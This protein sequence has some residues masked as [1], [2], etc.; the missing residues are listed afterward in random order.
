MAVT[1][2]IILLVCVYGIICSIASAEETPKVKSSSVS[3]EYNVTCSPKWMIVTVSVNSTSAQ[4]Y[5]ERL[6][7]YPDCQAELL[8][9]LHVFRLPLD[10][11]YSC[12][13]TRMLNKITGVRIYYHRVIV[14]EPQEEL[15]MI[16]VT[17]SIPPT[18][19]TSDPEVVHRTRRNTLP[20]NFVEPDYVNITDYIVASAPVPYLN[21]AVRQHGKIMD[22]TL[23]VQPGTP[24]EML[25]Y[26]DRKSADTYG[27]L[28]S[29][30]KVTDSSPNQ[31]EVII[32]NGCSIDPYIFGNFQSLENGDALSAKF[33][34]F[35]FPDANY[36]L[37]V[38]TVSVCLQ[39]CRGVPCGNGQL[40]YGRRRRRA[41][42]T[43]LPPDPN[44]VFEVEM[45][46]FLKVEYSE[47][48]FTLNK[49]ALKGAFEPR[50]N[51]SHVNMTQET[52]SSVSTANE[53]AALY[54][55]SATYLHPSS[56]TFVTLATVIFLMM[57]ASRMWK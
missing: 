33:R 30:L 57:H 31:E 7:T 27:L 13:T 6:K 4:V 54:R 18:H 38:G 47:D 23:N 36:V 50:M 45:T 21:I 9:G 5:L 51:V 22:T 46:T 41:I 28:T 25:I 24:L 40:G 12:G 29:F 15:Q 11:I 3:V 49:G 42:P 39:Q 34:A 56:L 55:N 37:F 14:E 2:W 10:N 26:L 19:N 53:V 35:K 17:C 8:E 32:M 1:N 48:H 16:L 20:E 43:D 44:K 52:N